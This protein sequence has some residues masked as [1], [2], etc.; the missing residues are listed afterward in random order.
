MLW[1]RRP[2]PKIVDAQLVWMAEALL[3]PGKYFIKHANS[4]MQ[5]GDRHASTSIPRSCWRNVA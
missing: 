4:F 3:V 5:V 2:P 1:R